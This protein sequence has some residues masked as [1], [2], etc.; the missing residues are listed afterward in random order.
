M[1]NLIKRFESDEHENGVTATVSI[2]YTKRPTIATALR[3]LTKAVMEVVIEAR[4]EQH[5]LDGVQA[6]QRWND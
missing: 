5:L 6:G 4:Q 3:L 1:S 2:T